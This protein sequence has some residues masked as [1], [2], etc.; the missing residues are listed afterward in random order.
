MSLSRLHKNNFLILGRAGMDLYADPPGTE[1]EHAARFTSALGGSSANTAAGVTRLGGAASLVTSVSDDA[2]GRFTRNELKKY[3]IQD[4]YVAT[5]SGEA[6]N[7]LAVVETRAENCQSVIYRNGAADFQVTEAQ[8]EKIDLAPFGA[9]IFTGTS[10]AV[11]PSRGA[12]MLLIQRANRAGLPVMLDID[13][14]PYS[15]ASRAEAASICNAAAQLC[16]IIVGND[17]EFAL[18]AGADGD[19]LDKAAEYASRPD[20]IVVHKM[21]E[22]GSVTFA[23]GRRFETGIFKVAA[24]KPTGAGDAFLASFCFSL[25]KGRGVEDAVRRGSA[26]AAIVVTRVG[27]APAMPTLAELENFMLNHTQEI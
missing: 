16:D 2:V 22:R 27:C 1:T 20:R 18:L 14:R 8:V 24:L 7:S 11:Q 15:W 17:E 3:E 10:L 4:R 6:R 25:A 9:L 13:Y 23:P 26:A 12:S 19:S 21:G 5:V